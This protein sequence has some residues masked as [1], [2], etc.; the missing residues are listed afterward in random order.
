MILV[1]SVVWN[2][3]R[4]SDLSC[5]QHLFINN[6]PIKIT[7]LIDFIPWSFNGSPN[8][9]LHIVS[10][11]LVSKLSFV[12]AVIPSKIFRTQRSRRSDVQKYLFHCNKY[13]FY[14]AQL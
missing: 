2:A 11:K 8:K 13:I 3:L 10:F 7:K 1:F 6:L 4:L 5:I 9:T 12:Q 14:F